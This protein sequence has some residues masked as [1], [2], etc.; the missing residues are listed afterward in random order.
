MSKKKIKAEETP[1]AQGPAQG[2]ST[3]AL[4]VEGAIN[5][6]TAAGYGVMIPPKTTHDF[7]AVLGKKYHFV[8]VSEDPLPTGEVNNLVQNAFAN[9]AAPVWATLGSKGVVLVDVNTNNQVR[10]RAKKEESAEPPAKR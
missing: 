4:T 5:K 1:A 3:R 2:K 10:L 8:K 9:E 6:Y 7:I